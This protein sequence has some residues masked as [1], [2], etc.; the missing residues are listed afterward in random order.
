MSLADLILSPY[1][2]DSGDDV[3]SSGLS[4]GCSSG[5][6]DGDDDS[7]VADAD[8]EDHV[9]L[10]AAWDPFAHARCVLLLKPAGG[11]AGCCCGGSVCALQ[12]VVQPAV[13]RGLSALRYYVAAG[14]TGLPGSGV[15]G[16]VIDAVLLR[17][18]RQSCKS[19]WPEARVLLSAGRAVVTCQAPAHRPAAVAACREAAA[20]GR[21]TDTAHFADWEAHSRGIA[22]KLLAGMGY[23]RGRGLGR[24]GGRG[25]RCVVHLL[26]CNC[27]R[28]S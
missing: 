1:A 2:D 23:V 20:A 12:R 28:I 17:S 9:G 7:D 26:S 18:C 21:Q 10:G 5:D 6:D 25:W 27:L 14:S 24:A 4:D 16:G 22:S 19:C 8:D 15:T 13:W 3:G 11:P